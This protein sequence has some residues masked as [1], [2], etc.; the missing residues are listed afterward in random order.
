MA[1]AQDLKI[2]NGSFFDVTP[3]CLPSEKAI[4]FTRQKSRFA[5][6]FNMDQVSLESGT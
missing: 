5:F 3:D 6:L 1:D 4:V 2:L